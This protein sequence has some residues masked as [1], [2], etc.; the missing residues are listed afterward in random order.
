[1]HAD[2][3]GFTRMSETLTPEDVITFI[4]ELFNLFDLVVDKHGVHKASVP[5]HP[6]CYGAV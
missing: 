2:L 4:N 3:V 6:T 5:A 1:M